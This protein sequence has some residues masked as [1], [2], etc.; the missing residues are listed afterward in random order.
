MSYNLRLIMGF[1]NTQFPIN[2]EMFD[3][4]HEIHSES[5]G[6]TMSTPI[7]YLTSNVGIQSYRNSEEF[8]LHG[9]KIVIL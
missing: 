6:F 5:V 9:A 2:S 1:Y 7:F 8:E 3:G 4:N